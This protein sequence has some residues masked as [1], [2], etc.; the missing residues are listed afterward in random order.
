M[1]LARLV[2]LTQELLHLRRVVVEDGA[3]ERRVALAKLLHEVSVT[4]D[5]TLKR[6]GVHRRAVRGERHRVR[7]ARGGAAEDHDQIAILH[8]G[9][10][11]DVR[12][13]QFSAVVGD[14]LFARRDVR[15]R[16]DDGLQ[17]LH[18]RLGVHVHGD[19]LVIVG[20]HGEEHVERARPRVGRGDAR[21]H[22][23]HQTGDLGNNA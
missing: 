19:D 5:V 4:A 20:R 18:H 12:V 2:R 17:V 16:L 3:V 1:A 10:A 21:S 22:Q 14:D 15:L 7:R 23:T 9:G 8:P 11:E 13:A 6:R